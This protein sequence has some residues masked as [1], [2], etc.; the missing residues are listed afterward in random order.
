MEQI[1]TEALS[2]W[3]RSKADGPVDLRVQKIRGGQSNPTWYLDWGNLRLVLRKKPNGQILR[4]AHA[5]EREFRV[6][7]ALEDTDVPVPKALWLEED[8]S[9][10]GTPFYVM[11]RI[12]G[13]VFSDCSLP[14]L[15][16]F[17]RREVYLDMARTL[18]RLHAVRP[19]QVGLAGFGRPSNYFKRQIAQWSKQY[20]DSTSPRIADLDRLVT[21]L[22]KNVPEDDGALSIAHGDF[23]LGNLMYHPTEPRVVAVLD[24]ELSTLGHPLADLGFCVMPWHSAPDEYGGILGT[25][26]SKLGIPEQDSFV[27]EYYA[28]ACPTK[29]LKRFHMAFALFRF[30]V[31]FLGISDRA[32][33]GNATAK[34]AETLG[35]LAEKF[36]A[37]AVQLTE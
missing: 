16:P 37:R 14:D 1:D 19:E 34:N 12:D 21:W 23:R 31:I 22:P 27:A 10:L 6:L 20:S 24:W 29:P 28:H 13:R 25:H 9:V 8:K 2:N 4:G 32:R 18:A 3:L 7:K 33:T 15:S 26:W 17:E 35:P 11:E 30:A 36:A 5:V